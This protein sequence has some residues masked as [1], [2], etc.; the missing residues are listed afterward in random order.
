MSDETLIEGV[1]DYELL[2]DP[3]NQYYHDNIRKENAWVAVSKKT[4]FPGKT[5]GL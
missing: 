3:R 4:G 1:R 2:Y 5:V